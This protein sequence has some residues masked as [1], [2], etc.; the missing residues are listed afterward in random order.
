[1]CNCTSDFLVKHIRML[2]PRQPDDHYNQ[3]LARDL[4]IPLQARLI[5]NEQIDNNLESVKHRAGIIL[6]ARVEEME[7]KDPNTVMFM[8]PDTLEQF[9]KSL[10]PLRRGERYLDCKIRIPWIVTWTGTSHYE[11]IENAAGVNVAT[12]NA[13][14]CYHYNRPLTDAQSITG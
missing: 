12:D 11:V 1:M 14:N 6:Q 10:V 3:L 5:L 13:G 2:G 7:H 4:D 8:D 9:C